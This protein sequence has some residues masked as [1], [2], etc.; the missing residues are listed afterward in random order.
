MKGTIY[1]LEEKFIL[2][3]LNEIWLDSHQAAFSELKI[4]LDFYDI[5][6]INSHVNVLKLLKNCELVD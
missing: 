6:K 1:H 4:F 3:G 2:R 5:L